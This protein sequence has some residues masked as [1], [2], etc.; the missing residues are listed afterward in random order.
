MSAP[1]PSATA[2]AG[3]QALRGIGLLLLAEMLF[4]VMDTIAKYLGA[5]L[6]VPMVVWGA[7]PFIWALC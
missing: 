1:P 3:Q 2:G 7:T 6:P 5:D 4:A